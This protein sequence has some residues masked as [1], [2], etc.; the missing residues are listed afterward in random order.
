MPV[1]TKSVP[2]NR[3]DYVQDKDEDKDHAITSA[4]TTI[5]ISLASKGDPSYS[6][7]E[8]DTASADCRAC[9]T[10][11]NKVRTSK[12]RLYHTVT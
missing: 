3:N 9:I 6:S 2:T 10:T 12:P 1:D 11:G 5:P 7:D 8:V 4:I